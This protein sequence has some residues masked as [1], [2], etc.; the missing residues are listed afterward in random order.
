M[1]SHSS[2]KYSTAQVFFL[3]PEALISVDPKWQLCVQPQF[4][5]DGWDVAEQ[6][7]H[8][9]RFVSPARWR[10]TMKTTVNRPNS[11]QS[12]I[13]ELQTKGSDS[14]HS[15]WQKLTKTDCAWAGEWN[16]HTACV[17]ER[18]NIICRCNYWLLTLHNL[19]YMLVRHHWEPST[20]WS[21]VMR[22]DCMKNDY[23]C[24]GTPHQA[25]LCKHSSFTMDWFLFQTF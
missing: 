1:G 13:S 24:S 25:V 5:S 14:D 9:T 17:R 4:C 19:F 2:L 11:P 18:V 23:M 20:L 6:N 3:W 10:S 12:A 22:H 8:L 15:I 7:I 21:A 16:T